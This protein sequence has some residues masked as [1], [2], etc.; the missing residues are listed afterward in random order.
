[1]AANGFATLHELCLT[2]QH[3]D[4]SVI[5]LQ[6]TNRDFTQHWI[7]DTVQSI[8]KEYFGNA[9]LVTATSCIP[10]PHSWKPGGVAL[11]VLGHWADAIVRTESDD[12]GR[13]CTATFAGSDNSSFTI[14]NAY[15]CVKTTMPQA[16]CHGLCPTMASPSLVWDP[17]PG[18]PSTVH[19]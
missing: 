15:N 7:R 13:W 19:H 12:L 17:T 2:L 5:A 9:R 4:V 3:H 16:P 18:S 8:L 6:E 14:I 1:L 10:A 11:A